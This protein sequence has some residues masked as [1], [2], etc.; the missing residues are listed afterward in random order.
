MDRRMDVTLAS[1]WLLTRRCHLINGET[2]LTSSK[3]LVYKQ[4]LNKMLPCPQGF[5]KMLYTNP[6]ARTVEIPRHH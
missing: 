4:G 6:S 3:F 1:L 5:A 2:Q